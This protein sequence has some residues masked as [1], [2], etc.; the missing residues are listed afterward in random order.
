MEDYGVDP[1]APRHPWVVL[2]FL[3][4]PFSWLHRPLLSFLRWFL[5]LLFQSLM[6]D[7]ST[8]DTR[9]SSWFGA[10]KVRTATI[11]AARYATTTARSYMLASPSEEVVM[12][13]GDDE[14]I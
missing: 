8:V 5:A 10:E 12:G 6:S 3:T 1:D 9:E 13:F 11:S 7:T 14:Y 2:W 4:R